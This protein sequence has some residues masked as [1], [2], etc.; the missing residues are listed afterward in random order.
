MRA[1]GPA[2]RL[3]ADR[4]GSVAVEFGIVA[5]PFFALMF[6]I[7]QTALVVFTGQVLDTALQDTARLIMT[8]QAQSMTAANFATGP[9]GLCS[10]IT[11]LFNCTAA[12]NAGTLQIDIR[13]PST[14]A[15]AVLTPPTVTGTS[16]NWGTSNGAPLY[17][18]PATSQIVIVRAAYLEPLYMSFSA[19][20]LGGKLDTQL[21]TAGATNSRLI[22]STVAFRNEPF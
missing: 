8:G 13:S 17:S 5:I 4:R 7:F 3:R 11:A 16:I 6:A 12:Y 19:S 2:L 20:F 18:N 15:N 9:N 10:R 22:L 1:A 14:F 21:S